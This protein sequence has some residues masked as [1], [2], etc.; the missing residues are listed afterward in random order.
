MT[1]SCEVCNKPLLEKDAEYS[2]TKWHK[3]VCKTHSPLNKEVTTQEQ[4]TFL[5]DNR[6]EDIPF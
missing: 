2:F 4:Q 6:I 3:V 5:M 1:G